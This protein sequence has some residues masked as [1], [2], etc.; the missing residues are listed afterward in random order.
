MAWYVAKSLEVLRGQLNTMAP[1]R[2]TV[3]DG[4]I[5]DAAHS[6]RTS[7][8][9]PTSSGQ[10]C[11]RDFTHDPGGGLD[12]HWLA[13]VLV[14]SGDSRIKYVIWD[15][16]IWTPGVGWKAYS[17]SNPHTQHLHLSVKA[18][19][20]GDDGRAWNLGTAT[21]SQ[22]E[23]VATA[24]EI[25]AIANATVNTLMSRGV[26]VG[27]PE[28]GVMPFSTHVRYTQVDAAKAAAGV[29]ALAASVDGLAAAVAA[30]TNDPGITLDAVKQIVTD[31]V[32]QSIEIVGEVRIGPAAGQ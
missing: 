5:G 4:S 31:A 7:D 17:G 29:K 32:K 3:S 21:P 11:A 12:C 14:A 8:H 22:E 26:G 6:S 13:R 20:L 9:N 16:R 28:R 2:S 25:Q 15:R 23:L 10:V 30:A 27:E 19:A 18:G 24:E 1:R